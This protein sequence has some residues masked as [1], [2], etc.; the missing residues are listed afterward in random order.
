MATTPQ[1]VLIDTQSRVGELGSD[2]GGVP[3]R[4]SSLWRDAVR[5][6]ARNRGA[7]LAAIVFALVVLFC[8]LAPVVSPYDPNGS[9]TP[10]RSRDRAPT[11]GSART[12]S[13][14]T[15]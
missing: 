9:T 1:E 5:R 6:Y 13:G 4:Q 11:T 2:M 14:V 7:L 12:S 8:L 10:W 3:V 15:C